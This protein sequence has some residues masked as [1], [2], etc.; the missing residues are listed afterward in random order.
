MGDKTNSLGTSLIHALVDGHGMNEFLHKFLESIGNSLSVSQLA[1]YDYD[2]LTDTFDLLYF[3]GYP[4]DFRSD[5]QKRIH[6]MDLRRALKERDPYWADPDQWQLLIPLYFQDI[7]EAILLV[8]SEQEPLRYGEEERLKCGVISRFLGLFMSSSRL[9]VN[10]KAE[11]LMV[12]DLERAREVQMNYLPAKHPETEKYELYGYNQSS[13]LVGG[14]YFDYFWLQGNS[15]QCVIADACGHGLA[16]ALVM[17][18]F[19]GL[20]ISEMRQS[21]GLST[22]FDR[23]NQHLFTEGEL[24]Q[25]LTSIFFDYSEEDGCLRYFNA[26]HFDPLVIHEDASSSTLRV[27]GPPLGMFGWSKYEIGSQKISPG[28]MIVLFTD[29]LVELRNEQDE[30]FGVEGIRSNV[31]ERRHLPLRDLAEELLAAAA[32]FSQKAQPDDDLT[33]FLMRFR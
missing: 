30:F 3:C 7:L 20:L 15:V 14:D 6:S 31:I 12:T 26:G 21:G 8:E 29:G 32:Q 25:Y 23:L 33:L 18:T 22:L 27:G 24:I 11:H 5:L 28:D 2:E 10:K 17:S 1:L 16:A 4:D 13:A 19:R 9:P